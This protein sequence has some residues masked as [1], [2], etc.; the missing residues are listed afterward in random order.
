MTVRSRPLPVQDL[1]PTEEEPVQA[2][3][4]ARY[5]VEVV[6]MDLLRVSCRCGSRR[7]GSSCRGLIRRCGL[8]GGMRLVGQ[9]AVDR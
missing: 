9:W 4:A 8:L 5:W 6:R 3:V 7:T 2:P 1:I